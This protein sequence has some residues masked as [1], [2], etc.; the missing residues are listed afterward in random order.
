M[1]T[2]SL[3]RPQLKSFS[4]AVVALLAFFAFASALAAPPQQPDAPREKF[5]RGRYGMVAASTP[6]AVAAGARILRQGGNAADAAAAACFALMVT[7]PAMTSL[8]GRTQMVIYLADGTVAAIDGATE[9]PAVVP[10]LAGKEDDRRGYQVVPVPGNP[11]ALDML[12]KKYGRLKLAQV[13]QPAIELAEN[14]FAVTLAIAEIFSAEREKLTRNLG[15]AANFLKPDGSTYAAGEIFKQPRLARTLKEIARRGPATLYRGALGKA[16]VKD[17]TANGGYVR[18]SDLRA[19]E[20][21]AGV[22]HRANYRG[23]EVLTAGRRAWGG[24]LVEM[25]HIL[26]QFEIGRGEPTSQ[27]LE[28]LAR[29]IAQAIADRPQQVGSLTSKP[30]GYTLEEMATPEFG[31]KR[32]ELV[33]KQ[34]SQPASGSPAQSNPLRDGHE[35]THLSV[36]DAEGNAVALTTSIGPRFGDGLATLELGFLYAHSYRMDGEPMPRLRD[37]TEQ[38]PTIVLK[39][40]RPVLAL[41]AAGSARIPGTVLQVISN[42]VDRGWPLEGAVAAP[43]LYCQGVNVRIH[44]GFPPQTLD[45]LRAAGLKLDV[46]KQAS[47]ARHV[48]IVH[49]VAFDPASGEFTGM[50]DPAYDGAAAGPRI[51]PRKK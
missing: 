36:I 11:A 14:G 32:A 19:Y 2:T 22:V 48:G 42:V 3:M 28:I 12:V 45:A 23:Y 30:V 27:E 25:L 41:G 35:T 8:G 47:H 18:E 46:V 9:S 31:R 51:A 24:T 38:T 1:T 16:L 39:N 44:E 40:G 7:D 13:M 21:L 6:Y 5:A 4:V 37:E 34:L 33:R 10:P 26:A 43:R 20:A 50:A 17:V 29:T 15:A 49:A